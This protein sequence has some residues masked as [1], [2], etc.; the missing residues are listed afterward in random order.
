MRR[1]VEKQQGS[2]RERER[3]KEV[4]VVET[5]GARGEGG[6]QRERAPLLFHLIDRA[7]ASASAQRV[8][9]AGVEHTPSGA[10]PL[11]RAAVVFFR[12]LVAY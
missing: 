1:S 12:A 3:E 9:S 4:K 6:R 10:S 8:K 11:Q 5:Q 7:G 2:E